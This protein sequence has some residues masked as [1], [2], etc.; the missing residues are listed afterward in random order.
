[1]ADQMVSNTANSSRWIASVPISNVD[2]GLKDVE[3]NLT[4]FS[5]P[6]V[7]IGRVETSFKGQEVALPGTTLQPGVKEVTFNYLIADKWDNYY[8]LYKWCDMLIPQSTIMGEASTRPRETGE[9]TAA[10]HYLLPVRVFL[11]DEFKNP[12][13]KFEYHNCWISTFGELR[14]SY[15]DDPSTL[16]HSFTINYTDFTIEKVRSFEG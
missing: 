2:D 9:W 15:Q 16:N 1:M 5:I 14:L 6:P 4:E 13:L 8:S 10:L 12:I 7:E 11:L 3:V